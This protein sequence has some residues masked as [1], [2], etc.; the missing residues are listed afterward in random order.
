MRLWSF[1]LIIE[2]FFSKLT[3]LTKLLDSLYKRM[4][5]EEVIRSIMK[6]I[7]SEIILMS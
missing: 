1:F 5:S 2:F 6:Y 3:K 4:S 7:M